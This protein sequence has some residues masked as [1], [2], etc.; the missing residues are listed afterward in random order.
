MP[1]SDRQSWNQRY[2]AGEFGFREPDPFVMEAHKNYLQPLLRENLAPDADT[3]LDLAGGAGHHAIWH[4]RSSVTKW[5]IAVA[6][7]W[8][9]CDIL[10]VR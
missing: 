9:R 8:V 2:L 7:R 3:G 1:E 10:Q 5:A 4:M 6:E